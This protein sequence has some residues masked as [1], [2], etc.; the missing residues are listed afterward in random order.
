VARLFKSTVKYTGRFP[1]STT[2]V[3]YTTDG[4]KLAVAILSEP[5]VR[6]WKEAMAANYPDEAN[7]PKL[8]SLHITINL[9]F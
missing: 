9:P 1:G 8:R 3:S 5:F 7:R 4:N 6:S 2:N